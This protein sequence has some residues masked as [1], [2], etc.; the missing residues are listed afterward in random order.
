MVALW[1]L[2]SEQ[3]R[4]AVEH[5]KL[6]VH[7]AQ[8]HGNLLYR[9]ERADYRQPVDF[10]VAAQP[11]PN[12]AII[13]AEGPH[14]ELELA[15]DAENHLEIEAVLKNTSPANIALDR[16]V[17]SASDLQLGASSEGRLSFFKNGYQSWTETRAFAATDRQMVTFLSPMSVMQENPRNLA[18][19]KQGE[20]N[21][22]M[23]IYLNI[24]FYICFNFKFNYLIYI[25]FSHTFEVSL[26]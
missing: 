3:Q 6:P 20:F 10:G 15:F 23:Y 1:Q 14:L 25:I 9:I 24:L 16:L 21:S 22:D 8:W 19:G 18:S 7:L 11:T 2:K 26:I 4:F 5:I 17:L 12:K 13:N